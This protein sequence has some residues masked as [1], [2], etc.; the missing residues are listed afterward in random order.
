MLTLILLELLRPLLR[1]LIRLFRQLVFSTR[2]RLFRKPSR[3][4]DSFVGAKLAL[5]EVRCCLGAP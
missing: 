4:S 5:I 1:I 3:T 2:F